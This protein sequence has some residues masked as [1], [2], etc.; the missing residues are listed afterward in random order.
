MKLLQVLFLRLSCLCGFPLNLKTCELNRQAISLYTPN[1]QWL[2]RHKIT[3]RD[4]LVQ[5]HG[6]REAHGSHW[7]TAI[8]KSCSIHFASSLTKVQSF[9][10]RV[11][12]CGSSL[13]SLNSW[14]CPLNHPSFSRRKLSVRPSGFSACFRPVEVKSS[15]GLLHFVLLVSFS[16]SWHYFCEKNSLKHFMACH[17]DFGK[18]FLSGTSNFLYLPPC[19]L[20]SLQSI[21]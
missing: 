13:Y 8:L 19:I 16:S 14:F 9:S 20:W 5:K 4:T 10:L 15:K 2:D 1:I 12:L 7:S 11:I 21:L 18:P 6:K 3:V 17:K